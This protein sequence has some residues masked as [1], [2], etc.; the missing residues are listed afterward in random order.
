VASGFDLVGLDLSPVAIA[1]L[2]ER[3]PERRD[4]LVV[5]DLSARRNPPE[6]GQTLELEGIYR[7]PDRADLTQT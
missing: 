7:H 2:A 1:Q 5:G 3:M 6:N 4:R